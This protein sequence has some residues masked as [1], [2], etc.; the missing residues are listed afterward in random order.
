[1][2]NFD[3]LQT[4]MRELDKIEV[5]LRTLRD[6]VEPKTKATVN[7][8]IGE[9]YRLRE[10]LGPGQL[11]RPERGNA[12]AWL[13]PKILPLDHYTLIAYICIMNLLFREIVGFMDVIT[14]LL[15]DEEYADMQR[16][17]RANPEKG[18]IIRGIGGARKVRAK[19]GSKG[20]SGGVRVIYYF[21]REETIWMLTAYSKK[22]KSDLSEK[23]KKVLAH[24]I[25]K[26]K[27]GGK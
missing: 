19:T 25:E 17:L 15:T 18:D 12:K 22:E 5:S 2:N 8:A 3:H 20:K 24:I 7:A 10:R 9:A 26:I 21:Q 11:I 4:I 14:D 6:Y 16:E 1:M 27:G 13:K 23:E